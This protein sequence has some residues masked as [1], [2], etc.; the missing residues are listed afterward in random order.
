LSE[1]ELKIG[2]AE[3]SQVASQASLK[4]LQAKHAHIQDLHAQASD[5]VRA[6]SNLPKIKFCFSLSGVKNV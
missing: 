2:L 1:L 3:S 6:F 5:Q 4:E